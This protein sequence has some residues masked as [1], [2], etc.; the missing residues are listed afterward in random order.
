M[1]INLSKSYGK[2]VTFWMGSK[3][4]VFV[5]EYEAFKNLLNKRETFDRM[6][7]NLS[8]QYDHLINET[9]SFV[10]M[11]YNEEL[12]AQRKLAIEALR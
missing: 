3:P 4:V 7:E 8:K 9:K 10:T 2:V 1:F 11:N 12:I 5:N 6:N